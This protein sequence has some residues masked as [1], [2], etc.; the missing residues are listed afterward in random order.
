MV[1]DVFKAITGRRSIRKFANTPLKRDDVFILCELGLHA[2][3]AGDIQDVKFIV[4]QDRQLIRALPGICMD[5]TWISGAA[6]IIAV[7]SKPQKQREYFG[8]HGELFARQSG[9]AATQNILIGAYALGIGACWVSGF[10][11][12]KANDLFGCNGNGHV[13]SIV[14]LGK[15]AEKP[16]PKKEKQDI[17][18]A[19]FFDQY[20]NDKVD[21]EAMNKDY[22]VKFDKAL[23]EA[24]ER[25]KD[26]ETE[27]KPWLHQLRDKTQEAI[28]KIKDKAKK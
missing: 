4:S 23:Q 28:K 24:E 6:T 22:A 8:E 13:E 11:Q 14:V 18:S 7:C 17:R 3:T 10:E 15:P 2:P 16:G 25:L 5:Q 12:E 1:M 19:V 27:V 20:G 21:I 9:A 26:M